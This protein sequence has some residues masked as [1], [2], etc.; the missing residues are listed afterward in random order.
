VRNIDEDVD[1][2]DLLEDE[3]GDTV[4][5]KISKTS[6]RVFKA[7]TK[8]TA[9]VTLKI[10]DLIFKDLPGLV[11]D[12]SDEGDSVP[13]DILDRLTMFEKSF[14]EAKGSPELVSLPALAAC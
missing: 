9:I 14:V 11:K 4:Q 10:V 12:L 1:N 6:A 13:T 3:D 7:W 2:D 5:V 8:K